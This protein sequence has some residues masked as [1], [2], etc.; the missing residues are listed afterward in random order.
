MLKGGTVPGI[1][2][3]GHWLALPLTFVF[4]L[5]LGGPLG[6]ELG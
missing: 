1:T 3:L 6:E 2:D 4:V 5:V